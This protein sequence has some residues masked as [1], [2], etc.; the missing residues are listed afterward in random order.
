MASKEPTP[1]ICP[2]MSGVPQESTAGSPRQTTQL[3]TR[4]RAPCAHCYNGSPFVCITD[5]NQAPRWDF[6][7][8]KVPLAG[9]TYLPSRALISHPEGKGSLKSIPM[10]S[11]LSRAGRSGDGWNGT[12]SHLCVAYMMKK[13]KIKAILKDEE[14]AVLSVCV[15]TRLCN[16]CL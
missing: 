8:D 4:G 1:T 15:F 12:F 9:I 5:P 16:M 14:Q 13:Q 7:T 2:Q 10:H 3:L 11:P 6:I